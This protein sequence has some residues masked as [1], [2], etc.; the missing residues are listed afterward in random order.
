MNLRNSAARLEP[1]AT[2]P[3]S[4]TMRVISPTVR[5]GNA[6][7]AYVRAS[8]TMPQNSIAFGLGGRYKTQYWRLRRNGSV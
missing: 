4:V 5:E 3:G 7:L 8:D 1:V 6:A 2:A